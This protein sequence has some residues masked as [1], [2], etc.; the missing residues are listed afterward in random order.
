M[1]VPVHGGHLLSLRILHSTLPMRESQP[2]FPTHSVHVP[3]VCHRPLPSGVRMSTM[4][5]I[6]E[7]QMPSSLVIYGSP[8][9]VTHFGDTS[10]AGG[11]QMAQTVDTVLTLAVRIWN[12]EEPPGLLLAV[13]LGTVATVNLVLVLV[14]AAVTVLIACIGALAG[15]RV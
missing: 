8:V 15:I 11:N 6:H 13:Q 3:R 7:I 9:A 12:P 10:L 14:K 2:H 4:Q 5:F 1:S